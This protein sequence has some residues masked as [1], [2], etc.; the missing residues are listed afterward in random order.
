MKIM[1]T[2]PIAAISAA[3]SALEGVEGQTLV[4][5]LV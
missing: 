5:R 1:L 3:L 2:P 4:I